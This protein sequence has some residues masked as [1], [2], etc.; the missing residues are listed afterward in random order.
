MT[1]QDYSIRLN[2]LPFKSDLSHFIIYRGLRPSQQMQGPVGGEIRTYSLPHDPANNEERSHY[3]VSL[4]PCEGFEE[5]YISPTSNNDLTKWVL[6][7][8]ICASAKSQLKLEEFVATE[9]GFLNEV[10]FPLRRH[11]EGQEELIVQPYFLR[12]THSFGFLVDFHFRLAEGV[13][14]SRRV[15]QLSLSLDKHFKRNLV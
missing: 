10:R 5:C 3:W 9:R 6:Y 8:C 7:Q 2:F 15:Q 11:N 12:A 14:H 13:Q 1:T 4:R